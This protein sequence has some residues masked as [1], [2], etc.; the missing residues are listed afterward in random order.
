MTQININEPYERSEGRVCVQTIEDHIPSRWPSGVY[1]VEG[2]SWALQNGRWETHHSSNAIHQPPINQRPDQGLTNSH[3][4]SINKNKLP[5]MTI[6]YLGSRAAA[7]QFHFV[8]ECVNP[9]QIGS[10][11]PGWSVTSRLARQK[12]ILRASGSSSLCVLRKG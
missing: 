8:M 11:A 6:N 1:W 4:L 12:P 3:F 2:D 5:S 7:Y 10:P 9:P